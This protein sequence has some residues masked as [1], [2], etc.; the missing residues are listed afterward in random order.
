MHVLLITNEISDQ[1]SFCKIGKNFGLSCQRFDPQ[2]EG[3]IIHSLSTG[4]FSTVFLHTDCYD[5]FSASLRLVSER[6]PFIPII[7]FG[8]NHQEQDMLSAMDNGLWD[9]MLTDELTESILY[10]TLLSNHKRISSMNLLHRME[11]EINEA[12]EYSNRLL[13]RMSHEIR[14]PMNAVIGM[15]EM[16]FDTE[17]NSKQRYYI[18]TIHESGTLLVALFN[19][20]LDYSKIEAGTIRI[21]DK[22]FDLRESMRESIVSVM[23]HALEKRL[24]LLYFF[25]PTLPQLFNG[26]DLRLRQIVMNLLENAIKFTNQG[27]VRLDVTKCVGSQNSWLCFKVSDSGIG[28]KSALIPQLFKPY[29]QASID[30][31]SK[32]GVGLG[33]TICE[34]LVKRMKGYVEVHSEPE[35]GSIFTIRIPYKPLE[36]SQGSKPLETLRGKKVLFLTADNVLDRLVSEY[37]TYNNMEIDIKHIDQEYPTFADWLPNYDLLI[38][39]LRTNVKIDLRLIDAVREK[40]S[41]P[42]ILFKDREKINDKPIVIRKDT[43]ILLKPLD[44]IELFD[45]MEAVLES[46]A[47]DLNAIDRQIQLDERMG[48]YHPLDI[49]VAEDNAINQ[50]IIMSV[51]NRYGYQVKLVENGKEAV[52][53]LERRIYDVVL[54]D[55]QMP[56]MD[57]ISATKL[58]RERFNKKRQPYIVALTADALQ[59]GK[60]EYLEQ[61]VDELLYKPVQ[62]KALMQL[63]AKCHRLDR[64]RW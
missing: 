24:E 20:L 50:R 35:K 2:N 29:V 53:S 1:I 49:L 46:R 58:I 32:R 54:M 21:H 61:G 62:T 25:D 22:P 10:K 11:V 16:L 63:L 37:L 43:V 19:D 27:F 36:N 45:T 7:A 44:Y 30:S 55:I 64:G 8:P 23:E 26:D 33:L 40:K 38:T 39:H 3:E 4:N 52:E 31:S 34:H 12:K 5:S 6:F 18:D 42:H 57:G 17:L 51:L 59:Q 41:I 48:E 56:V 15:A 13:A 9:Y 47:D 28:I 60:V 14:T